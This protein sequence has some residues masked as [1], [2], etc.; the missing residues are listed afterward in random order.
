MFYLFLFLGISSFFCY[1]NKETINA[2]YQLYNFYKKTV[3]P[4]GKFGHFYTIKS[5]FNVFKQRQET[6]LEKFNKK[7]LKISY[8][9]KDKDYFYL[10]KIPKGIMPLRS[11]EDEKG[12]NINDILSPYLGPNLDCHGSEIYPKDFGYEKIKITTVFDRIITFEEN[13]KIIL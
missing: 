12:N 8:K 1:K 5:I 10:L 2:S 6:P 7:Y 3:D 13:D 4:D 11:I 9:Y